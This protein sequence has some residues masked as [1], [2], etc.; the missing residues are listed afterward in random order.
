MQSDSFSLHTFQI[1]SMWFWLLSCFKEGDK[2]FTVVDSLKQAIYN[3]IS[4]FI[5]M[6]LEHRLQFKRT[7]SIYQGF[8][9]PL[10]SSRSPIHF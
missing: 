2:L 8:T 7:L 6:L 1:S 9:G 5:Q 4:Y 10:N 3:G